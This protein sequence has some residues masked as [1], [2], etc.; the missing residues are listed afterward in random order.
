[1]MVIFLQGDCLST[2]MTQSLLLLLLLVAV[3]EVR[4]QTWRWW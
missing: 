3:Q 1:M 2:P 4:T